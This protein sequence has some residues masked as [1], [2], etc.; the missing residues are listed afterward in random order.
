LPGRPEEKVWVDKGLGQ[1]AARARQ[2]DD[3][4]GTKEEQIDCSFLAGFPFGERW[5]LLHHI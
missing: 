5:I 2:Q 4:A 3:F 1:Q